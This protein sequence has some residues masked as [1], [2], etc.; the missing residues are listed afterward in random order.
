MFNLN[1]FFIIFTGYID[2]HQHIDSSGGFI[3]EFQ[4]SLTDIWS[5]IQGFYWIVL[6]LAIFALIF[7]ICRYAMSS[8][9][10]SPRLR[11][12]AKMGLGTSLA[13]IALTGAAPFIFSLILT[14]LK[15]FR[16]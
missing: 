8:I 7:S 1:K 9:N 2:P 15:F 3:D 12:E 6:G 4:N 10:N 13:V 14:L 16:G 11:D 5:Y